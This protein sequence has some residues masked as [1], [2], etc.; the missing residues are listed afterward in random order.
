M[1][2]DYKKYLKGHV[3]VKLL[4]ESQL[5]TGNLYKFLLAGRQE[6]DLS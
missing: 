1:N 5:S 3:Q 2:F 6:C 4:I